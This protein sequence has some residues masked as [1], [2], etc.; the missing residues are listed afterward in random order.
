MHPCFSMKKIIQVFHLKYQYSLQKFTQI[1]PFFWFGRRF[2]FLEYSQGFE[3]YALYRN[4]VPLYPLKDLLRIFPK[5]YLYISP[6]ISKGIHMTIFR[7][8]FSPFP[9]I[10]VF[11]LQN[12]SICHSFYLSF[13][14]FL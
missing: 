11:Y 14:V 10:S 1:K 2:F 9:S 12:I 4:T 5:I 13:F 6:S 8:S 3:G 7:S